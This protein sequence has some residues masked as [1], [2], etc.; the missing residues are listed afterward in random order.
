MDPGW[1]T[2]QGSQNKPTTGGVDEQTAQ[3]ETTT[4]RTTPEA[5]AVQSDVSATS[6]I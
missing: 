5:R 1:D 4:R 3:L 6:V 2:F